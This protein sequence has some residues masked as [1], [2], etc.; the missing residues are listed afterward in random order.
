M[1]Q[2]RAAHAD[3]HAELAAVEAELTKTRQAIDRYLAAF[4]RGTMDEELV[5]DR[6]SELRAKTKQLR[7]RRDELTL[8]F[9]DEPTAPEPPALTAMADHVT[10]IIAGGTHNRTKA[11][12][13]ALVAQVTITGPDRLVPVFRISQPRNEA[14]LPAETAPK[15]VVRAMTKSVGRPGLEP[16]T[17]RLKVCSS[18]D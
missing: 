5:A 18:T 13:E 6:L 11:L 1:R 14:A 7:V 12:V 15:G 3:R 17:Y 9:D 8:A 2:H 4:Q 16:G 10:E